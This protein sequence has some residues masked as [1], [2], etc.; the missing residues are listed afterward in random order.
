MGDGEPA[1]VRV[2]GR[3]KVLGMFF[4]RSEPPA[5]DPPPH[6]T[7]ETAVQDYMGQVVAMRISLEARRLCWRGV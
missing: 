1:L 5:F 3:I 4:N 6:R 7:V 2:Q